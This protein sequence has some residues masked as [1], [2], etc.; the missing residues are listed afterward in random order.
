MSRLRGDGHRRLLTTSAVT[1]GRPVQLAHTGAGVL[2]GL[3]QVAVHRGAR[4]LGCVVRG[5]SVTDTCEHAAVSDLGCQP[6]GPLVRDG[7]VVVRV[8]DQRGYTLHV[9]APL[10]IGGLE[11]PSGAQHVQ[12]CLRSTLQMR[13]Q[14]TAHLDPLL[15]VRVRVDV[16]DVVPARIRRPTEQVVGGTL[17]WR[18][19]E[20]RGVPLGR[21]SPDALG[22]IGPVEDAREG[23]IGFLRSEPHRAEHPD[24]VPGHGA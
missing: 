10:W 1:W 13:G 19:R 9:Q 21:S 4:A 12:P 15:H 17:G 5:V 8:H 7:R 2:C 3:N 11:R 6:E 18:P 24:V 23:M 16:G 22:E 20:E 14:L